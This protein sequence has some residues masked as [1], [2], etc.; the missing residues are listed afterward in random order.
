MSRKAKW[1]CILEFRG[2][3]Y[4]RQTWAVSPGEVLASV[5]ETIR[6]G[7]IASLRHDS[8]VNFI[9]E[10]RTS[11]GDP[12]PIAGMTGVYCATI[13]ARRQ[14]MLAHIIETVS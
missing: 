10:A 4:V 11:G 9:D 13:V 8:L 5:L 14:M 1:T 2:G 3:T 6:P 12:T 7:D